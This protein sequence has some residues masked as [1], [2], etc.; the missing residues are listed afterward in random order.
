[1]GNFENPFKLPDLSPYFKKL[2]E[3]KYEVPTYLDNVKPAITPFESTTPSLGIESAPIIKEETVS[4]IK[5]E[6]IKGKEGLSNEDLY[7][8]RKEIHKTPYISY[9]PDDVWQRMDEICVARVNGKVA[10]V[11][12]LVDLGSNWVEVGPLL[13]MQD[14]DPTTRAIVAVHLLNFTKE[15]IENRN[16]F[17]TS[18]NPKVKE[19]AQHV[20]VFTEISL[21]KSLTIL[22]ILKRHLR[23]AWANISPESIK[24]KAAMRKEFGP[25]PKEPKKSGDVFAIKYASSK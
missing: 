6:I 19:L 21:L 16:A 14:Y 3:V 17:W 9:I 5:T 10:G 24:A 25:K 1:M 15:G 12:A 13:I 11:M 7:G 2:M 20:P 22:P 18:H 4:K 23:I 8:I